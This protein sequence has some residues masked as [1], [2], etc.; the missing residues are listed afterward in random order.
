[1]GESVSVMEL[2]G[3]WRVWHETENMLVITTY[4]IRTYLT[5]YGR[6]W[7]TCKSHRCVT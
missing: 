3:I 1:M 7:E 6:R 4:H 5:I 2:D